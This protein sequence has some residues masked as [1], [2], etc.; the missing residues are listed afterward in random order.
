MDSEPVVV[1]LEARE[2]EAWPAE[3]VVERGESEWKTLIS[4]G[5][6]ESRSIT[7]G[8]ARLPPEG[9]L[10]AHRHEQSEAYLVL[11]GTGVVTIGGTARPL[12]EGVAVFIPGDTLHSVRATGESDLRIAYV[13]AADSFDDVEYVFS[14]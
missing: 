7:M 4:A 13:L 1:D 8:V 11:A 5:L 14:E 3:Q 10:H 6:T 2:W 9:S 12:R